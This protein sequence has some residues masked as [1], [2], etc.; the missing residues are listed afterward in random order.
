M[1]GLIEMQ[2]Q[3]N[4]KQRQ[5]IAN[6]VYDQIRNGIVPPDGN[7]HVLMVTSFG[8]LGGTQVFSF[9]DKYTTQIGA[10]VSNIQNEGR[11]VLDIK[12]DCQHGAGATGGGISYHTLIV[13]R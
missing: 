7:K 1:M 3:H 2:R 4:E 5:E 12:F 9:D 11:E 8:K 10:I 13:Y 6:G